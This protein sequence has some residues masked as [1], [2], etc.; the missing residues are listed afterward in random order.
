M[1]NILHVLMPSLIASAGFISALVDEIVKKP[2]YFRFKIV[3]FICLL[4]GLFAFDFPL[5]QDMVEKDTKIVVAEYVKYETNSLPATRK[6][7]FKTENG[8]LHVYAP[9]LARVVGNLESG[10][11]YEIEYFVNS[12]VIKEYRLIE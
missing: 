8:N 1:K 12:N 3:I 4:V 10:K 6:A 11:K 5:Y 2:K 9:T 7:Y